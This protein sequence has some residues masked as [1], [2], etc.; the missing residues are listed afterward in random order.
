[1]THGA[2]SHVKPYSQ[3]LLN[4]ELGLTHA[5]I[6][7]ALGTDVQNVREKLRETDFV[8]FCRDHGMN[9]TET[10]V[11]TG[12]RG[13]PMICY[14]LSVDA[15]RMFVASYNNEIGRE[16]LAFLLKCE[17]AIHNAVAEIARLRKLVVELQAKIAKPQQLGG[18][19]RKRNVKVPHGTAFYQRNIFSGKLERMQ[20]YVEKPYDKL[21]PDEKDAYDLAHCAK[22][23]E[24]IALKIRELTNPAKGFVYREVSQPAAQAC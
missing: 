19:G 2:I 16:Y 15:A 6:A 10:S 21:L 11:K 22:I 7:H 8:R 23:G 14:A 5:D 9:I 3:P 1:M 24:K 13:R 17:D 4:N 18:E 12:K 20:N